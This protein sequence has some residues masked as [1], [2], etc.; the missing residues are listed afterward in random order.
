MQRINSK[1]NRGESFEKTFLVALLKKYAIPLK[2]NIVE[3][4]R[5]VAV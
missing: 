4:R 1:G 3:I 5:L 2:G